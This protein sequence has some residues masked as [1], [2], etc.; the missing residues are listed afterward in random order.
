MDGTPMKTQDDSNLTVANPMITPSKSNVQESLN[1]LSH[2]TASTKFNLH[3]SMIPF[4]IPLIVNKEGELV[5]TIAAVNHNTV[6]PRVV[7]E[8]VNN[9]TG[10]SYNIENTHEHRFGDDMYFFAIQWQKVRLLHDIYY[11]FCSIL[12]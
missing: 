7:Y 2:S 8:I 10:N 4:A 3:P 5:M 12:K 9:M 1:F 6:Q 11:P